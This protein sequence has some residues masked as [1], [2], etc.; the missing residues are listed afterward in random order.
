MKKMKKEEEYAIAVRNAL[1]NLFRDEEHQDNQYHFDLNEVDA[2]KFFT[3]IIVACSVLY[4]DLTSDHKA[5][6]DFTYIANKLIVQ[7]MMDGDK[8]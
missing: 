8:S 4:N 1:L 5:A 2:T 6:L 3:G 7:W